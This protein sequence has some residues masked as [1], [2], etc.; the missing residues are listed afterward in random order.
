M[1]RVRPRQPCTGHNKH[2]R[3]HRPHVEDRREHGAELRRRDG[4]D[5][6]ASQALLRRPEERQQPRP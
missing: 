1:G 2:V 6:R 3:Q 5:L 4:E